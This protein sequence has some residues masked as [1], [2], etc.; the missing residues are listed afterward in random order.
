MVDLTNIS[1]DEA[2]RRLIAGNERFVSG[3]VSFSGLQKESLLD[4]AAGQNPFAT[5]RV[6]AI[7]E[8]RRN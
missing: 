1:A 2:L 8:C 7:H 5:I 4:L 3:E 6:A